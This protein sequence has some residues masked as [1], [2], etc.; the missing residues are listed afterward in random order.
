MLWNHTHCDVK[1][2]PTQVEGTREDVYDAINTAIA[3]HAK[4]PFAWGIDEFTDQINVL[5]N[6]R[7]VA[8]YMPF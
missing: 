6:G 7:I 5:R 4:N 8:T 3:A 1:F 2:L